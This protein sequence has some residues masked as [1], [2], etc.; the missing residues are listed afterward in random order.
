MKDTRFFVVSLLASFLLGVVI[1]SA[2]TSSRLSVESMTDRIAG[3]LAK[4]GLRLL[5]RDP[6]PTPPDSGQRCANQR[7]MDVMGADGYPVI[8]HGASL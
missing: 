1:A 5:F 3:R 2:V 6:A 8:D 7:P 4:I